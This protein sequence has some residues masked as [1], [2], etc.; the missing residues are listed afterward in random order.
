MGTQAES[1]V[2]YVIGRGKRVL[3]VRY[4]KIKLA[5]VVQK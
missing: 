4:V 1:T 3:F 2:E 5:I